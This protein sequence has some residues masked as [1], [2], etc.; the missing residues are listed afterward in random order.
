MEG[1]ITAP[2]TVRCLRTYVSC[3]LPPM[4]A[5]SEAAFSN[6]SRFHLLPHRMEHLV[7]DF[8]GF[9]LAACARGAVSFRISR[10]SS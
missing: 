9:G 10:T 3:S 4:N 7:P 6:L 1:I 8:F 5:A 2:P